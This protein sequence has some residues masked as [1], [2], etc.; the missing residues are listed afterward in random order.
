MLFHDLL[1]LLVAELLKAS[2]KASALVSVR[3][4]SGATRCRCV[5]SARWRE[6]NSLPRLTWSRRLIGA[7]LV[8]QIKE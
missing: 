6:M 8:E 3:E 7:I 4:K 2:M 1:R 5:H